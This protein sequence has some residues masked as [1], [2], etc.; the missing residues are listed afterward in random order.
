MSD[1]QP[2]TKICTKCG[3]PKLLTEFYKE[4]R[5]KDGRR[6]H[7]KAC[8]RLWQKTVWN[9]DK[10]KKAAADK[11]WRQNNAE[12]NKANHRKSY[13]ENRQARDKANREW[14]ISHPEAIQSH[15]SSYRQ[16]HKDDS[17][18]RA[19]KNARQKVRYEIRMD[20]LKRGPCERC[21][22]IHGIDG[23]EIEGHHDDYS[24]PLEVR[25]LCKM[26][27]HVDHHLEIREAA[28]P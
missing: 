25:W 2:I 19:K 7:C 6:S 17:D 15:R 23:V 21:G 10:A 12:R 13:Q 1:F 4:K 28:R 3:D 18:Y 11:Q 8:H 16:R 22:A 26:P 24:K 27:C 5:M 14:A 9:T 20:R